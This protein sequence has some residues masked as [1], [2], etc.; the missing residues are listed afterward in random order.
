LQVEIDGMFAETKPFVNTADGG[1]FSPKV[2]G[3]FKLEVLPGPWSGSPSTDLE[4]G[5][6]DGTAVYPV[7]HG[8]STPEPASDWFVRVYAVQF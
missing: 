7:R 3:S 4:T 6:A 8:L 5:G 2:V 1:G